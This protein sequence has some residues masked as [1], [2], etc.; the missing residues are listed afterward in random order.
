VVKIEDVTEFFP[1]LDWESLMAHVQELELKL[2]KAGSNDKWNGWSI[3]S[4]TG[5]YTN[6]WLSATNLEEIRQYNVSKHTNPTEI[7][8]PTLS[9]LISDL[10]ELGLTPVGMRYWQLLPASKGKWHCDNVEHSPLRI[11]FVV[12]TNPGCFFIT[13]HER[14][15]LKEHHAYLINVDDYHIVENNSTHETRTHLTANVKNTKGISKVHAVI[16]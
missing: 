15:H 5:K 16:V 8:T 1:N 10:Q 9:Q 2:P 14:T 7:I 13:E 11:H 4:E 3:L 6:G 12:K